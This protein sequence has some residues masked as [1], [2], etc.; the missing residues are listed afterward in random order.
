MKKIFNQGSRTLSIKLNN[1]TTIYHV[2]ADDKCIASLIVE[3]LTQCMLIAVY[4]VCTQAHQEGS[5]NSS[6]GPASSGPG[7]EEQS[8]KNNK[9]I[10]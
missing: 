6:G 2:L 4:H 8:L 1:A 10:I 7:R 3:Q 9:V 5:E